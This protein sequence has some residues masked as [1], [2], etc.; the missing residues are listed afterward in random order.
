[1][2]TTSKKIC[3]YRA[4]GN[5]SNPDYYNYYQVTVVNLF[6]TLAG[7]RTSKYEYSNSDGIRHAY[8]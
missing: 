8:I 2:G 1:M 3:M 5:N 7:I 4:R 6:S